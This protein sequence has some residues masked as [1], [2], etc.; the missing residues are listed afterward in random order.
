MYIYLV[1][2]VILG[3]FLIQTDLF[4]LYFKNC[5]LRTVPLD[6]EK[7]IDNGKMKTDSEYGKEEFLFV[8]LR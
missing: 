3:F 2:L 4:L 8:D 1:V 5:I 6:I 7:N